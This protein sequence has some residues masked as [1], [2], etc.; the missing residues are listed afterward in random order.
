MPLRTFLVR[1]IV[2]LIFARADKARDKGLVVPSD[3][4]IIRSLRY[5][6]GYGKARLLD[7]CRPAGAKG[8]L[9]VAL[10]VHGGGFCYGDKERYRFYC[11]ELCRYGYAVVNFN[12]RLLPA[13]FPAPMEDLALVLRFLKEHEKEYGLD[14]ENLFAVG[15]SAGATVLASFIAASRSAEYAR[16][17][18]FV[19]PDVSFRAV[20]L[21]SGV[22]DAGEGIAPPTGELVRCWLGKNERERRG[23]AKYLRFYE[24]IDRFPPAFLTYSVND[25]VAAGT[26]AF[27]A[28][29]Q[30][31]GTLT[32]VCAYGEG[33]GRV[34]H[35]FHLDIRSAE[36]RDVFEKQHAFF[37][38]F[39]VRGGG[40]PA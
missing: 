26:P 23:R 29:L 38:R 4:E 33:N 31:A 21:H 13:R 36:A 2:P 14:T 28:A 5:G 3:V 12:Y 8:R 20:A 15:D 7:I 11:A 32:Q 6:E 34:G 22:Y 19:L 35:V 39:L 17:F 1:K 30:S 37:T 25:F 24:W 16:A 40:F 10:S 27:C 18:P 9:P